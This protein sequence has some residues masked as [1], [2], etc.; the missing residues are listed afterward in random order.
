M[1]PCEVSRKFLR[2]V[3]DPLRYY[4]RDTDRQN[5][6][7]FLPASLLG[8]SSATR[9]ENSGGWI[10]N[11]Y[12]S[13]GEHNISENCRSCMVRFIRYHPV[14][15]TMCATCAAHITVLDKIPL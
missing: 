8:V 6:R 1:A 12:N 4:E 7:P 10:G 14:I 2:Q 13:D 5:Q 15:V 11:D 9:A 3:K